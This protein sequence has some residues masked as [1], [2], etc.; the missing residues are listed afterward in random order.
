LVKSKIKKKTKKK[1]QNTNLPPT[2]SVLL[3]RG[4]FSLFKAV[5]I[6]N[7]ELMDC[8]GTKKWWEASGLSRNLRLY[9]FVV[10]QFLL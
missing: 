8:L 3:I 2:F 10:T 6:Q 4:Q 5:L 9:T 7:V 1:T